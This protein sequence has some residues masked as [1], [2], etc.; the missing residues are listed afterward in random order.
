MERYH[1][2]VAS[3]SPA[4][5][6]P[7]SRFQRPKRQDAI[8]LA[9]ELFLRGERVDMNTVCASLGIGRTTLYRWVGDRERLLGEVLAELTDVAWDQVI[10]EA[11]GKGQERAFDAGRRF[12]ELTANYPPLR[13]FVEREP[14][15]ALRVLLAPDGPVAARIRA[16]FRRAF[17]DNGVEADPELIEIAVEAG[18]ALEWAPIAIGGEPAI[19]RASILI[20]GLFESRKR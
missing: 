11:D 15:L 4:A 9:R 8:E 12:M 14:N 7:E 10:R 2:A 16:G 6:A 13:E 20:R 19:G 5:V 18:T 3:S 17:E 1:P